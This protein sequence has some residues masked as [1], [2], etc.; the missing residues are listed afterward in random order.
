MTG[1]YMPRHQYTQAEFA[2]QRVIESFGNLHFELAEHHLTYMYAVGFRFC[3]LEKID[4]LVLGYLNTG[5]SPFEE[6]SEEWLFDQEVQSSSRS[7][8]ACGTVSIWINLR[9]RC[10]SLQL[11]QRVL[12]R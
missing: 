1:L 5:A 6:F 9:L 10:W 8:T 11:G 2:Q 7:E 12:L 4:Y 3:Q